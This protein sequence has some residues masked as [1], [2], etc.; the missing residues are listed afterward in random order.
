MSWLGLIEMLA[1]FGVVLGFAGW[2]WWDY[3]RWK[4]GRKDDE[5]P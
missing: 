4:R 3:R 5:T 1:F 2:Q